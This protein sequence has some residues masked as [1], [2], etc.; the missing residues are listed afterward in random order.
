MHITTRLLAK[1]P[2]YSAENAILLGVVRVILARNL[3]NRRESSGIGIDTMSYAVGNLS[4]SQH[5]SR[6]RF[7]SLAAVTDVL[8]D[9]DDADILP[10]RER[11]EGGFDR[12]GFGLVVHH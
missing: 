9:K 10:R 1:Q 8:V 5:V 3:E 4:T 2:T 6:Y 11:L 12:R 7:P